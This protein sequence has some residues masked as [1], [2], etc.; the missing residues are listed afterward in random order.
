MHKQLE[1]YLNQFA[2]RLGKLPR[3][4]REDELRE[5][6]QHVEALVASHRHDGKSED[7]AVRL[8]IAQFGRAEKIGHDLSQVNR[9]KDLASTAAAICIQVS[10]C[11]LLAYGFFALVNDKPTDFPYHQNDKLILAACLALAGVS[12]KRLLER[13]KVKA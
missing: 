10:V 3:A 13:K 7:E 2:L 1:E 5:I 4:Q 8:A 11:M 9:K 6:R 12:I